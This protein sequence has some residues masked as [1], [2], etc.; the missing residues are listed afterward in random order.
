MSSKQNEQ[1]A[2][3]LGNY[4]E[5]FLLYTDGEL[6]PAQMQSVEDFLVQHPDLRA[7][8]DLLCG[9][10]LVPEN[11]SFP[12]EDLLSHHMQQ[13]VIDEDLFLYM[14]NE[15]PAARKAKVEQDLATR[16]D[17]G[18]QL[19]A[20]MQTHL[21]AT[22]LI[23]YPNKKELYRKEER[24]AFAFPWMR[25]AA[26]V[27]IVA[28]AGFFY[29]NNNNTAPATDT[30]LAGERPVKIQPVVPPSVKTNEEAQPSTL[31]ET[32]E[33]VVTEPRTDRAKTQSPAIAQRSSGTR[34]NTGTSINTGTDKQDATDNKTAATESKTYIAN[35]TNAIDMQVAK[36]PVKA[37]EA[38]QM[39]TSAINNSPVTSAL[40]DR[41]TS[42]AATPATNDPAGVAAAND[43]KGSV[44]GFLRK[45]TRLIEKRTGLDPTN[46]GELLIG[47]VA[48]KLK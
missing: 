21:D 22:Q 19:E 31:A 44:K 7:E 1:P 48:V 30:A 33:P 41:T 5:F 42:E 40:H 36:A 47:V 46:D 16:P 18:R 24:A 23:A 32:R 45:A 26:A 20:L 14:D 34:I 3:H 12:K 39:A 29:F 25:V 27:A 38:N 17:Y 10:R 37:L 35:F 4:E 6:N 2:I 9:T 15:L 43:H 8:L 11:Y 13:S 28:A